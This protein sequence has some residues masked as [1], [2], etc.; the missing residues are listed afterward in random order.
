[1]ALGAQGGF[2]LFF[3]TGGQSGGANPVGMFV[4]LGLIRNDFLFRAGPCWPREGLVFGG[5]YCKAGCQQAGAWG[6]VFYALAIGRSSVGSGW[7]VGYGSAV[8]PRGQSGSRFGPWIAGA[9]LLSDLVREKGFFQ[10]FRVRIFPRRT[11][12]KSLKHAG[13]IGNARK[14]A[15]I[16][17][18]RSSFYSGEDAYPE[19][20]GEAAFEV[21]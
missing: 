15:G 8:K 14:A 7:P 17:V 18:G 11:R 21:R 16:W 9:L 20:G 19:Q 13:K 3:R 10:G 4:F 5:G 1:M 6:G 12:L 2:A